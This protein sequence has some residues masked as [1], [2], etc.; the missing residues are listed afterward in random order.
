MTRDSFRNH[1]HRGGHPR[2]GDVDL[3]K[4]DVD[5]WVEFG[6]GKEF[7]RELWEGWQKLY[8]EPYRGITADGQIQPDLYSIRA[9]GAPVDK[10]VEAAR[11]LVK[12]AD[13]FHLSQKLR[14]PVD[15]DE[16]R[17]WMNPEFSFHRHGVRFEKH[18]EEV[19]VASL[20][21]VQASLSD[22]GYEDVLAA[23]RTNAFLG[24]LVG[25]SQLMNERSYS[26][27]LFV[28]PS[29]T[30]PWGWSIWGHHL[31]F[32]VFVLGTQMV[33]SPVFR[34]CEP[35]E[36]D[37][38][39]YQG[40][41]MFTQEMRLASRVMEALSAA[42]RSQVVVYDRLEH[43]GMPE[44]FPHP[45]DGRNLA[46]AYQ[47]NAIVPYRGGKVVKFSQQAQQA[48][49]DLVERSIDFLPEGP[50]NA[51]MDD[52]RRH[53]DDTWFMWMGGYSEDDV[54][55]FRIHNP[56]LLCEFDHECGM[57]LTNGPPGRFHVHTV[58]RTPN[59]NDYGRELLRLWRCIPQQVK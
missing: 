22:R 20:R 52:V 3:S 23:M 40:T 48:V 36:V 30:G 17:C 55:H 2:L 29:T 24:G 19:W 45:A 9:Q 54:F 27:I 28:E 56:V 8:N 41:E 11:S 16:W 57:W 13:R 6:L 47:D 7:I 51:K 15:A 34:G 18:D 42:E 38:G 46:G 58:V 1:I 53:T 12:E 39:P 31:T 44:G 5:S 25:A 4:Y 14:Y 37:Q 26:F 32:C 35:N 10:M 49:W 21:L 33:V 59:G 50:L 43:P